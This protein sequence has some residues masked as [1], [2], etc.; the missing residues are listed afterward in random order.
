MRFSG[1]FTRLIGT[2]TILN[3]CVGS[4]ALLPSAFIF[5][6]Y[7]YP[8][9]SCS[10]WAPLLSAIPTYSNLQFIL[11]INPASGPGLAGSQPDVNYQACVTQ[12]RDAGMDHGNVKM[13]GYVRTGFGGLPLNNITTDIDT[14]AG[15]SATAQAGVDYHV[16]G[17]FFDEAVTN[18]GNISSYQNYASYAKMKLGPDAYTNDNDTFCSIAMLQITL[19]PGTWDDGT[20]SSD[21]FTFADMIVTFEKTF[22]DFQASVFPSGAST[23]RNKQTAIIHTGPE[24]AP[25][26]MVM[27]ITQTLGLGASFYSDLPNTKAYNQFPTSWPGYLD[28]LVSAQASTK[29]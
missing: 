29:N 13:I 15:W 12:L 20:S 22:N 16:E 4:L 25:M 5:P 10:N 19:N 8:N 21:V 14:Y 3:V 18:S 28:E 2:L 23:P 24:S 26:D 1:I 17:I 6:L 7:I 27:T 11:V 9:N